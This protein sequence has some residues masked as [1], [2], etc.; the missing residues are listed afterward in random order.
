VSGGCC[1]G[2][3]LPEVNGALQRLLY[4]KAQIPEREVDV[5]FEAPTK[6]WN[7]GLTRPAVS[8]YL[9]ELQENTE[10]RRT[11]FQTSV[12]N[13]QAIRRLPPR[14]FNLNYLV[15]AATTVVDDEHR[16]LWRVL[17][18][19]MQHATL[20]A[21]L[22]PEALRRPEPPVLMRVLP[23]DEAPRLL[24]VWSALGATPR[25]AFAFSITVP[26]DVELVI[27]APLVLTRTARVSQVQANGAS[28]TKVDIGGVIRDRSGTPLEGVIVT[29]SGRGGGGSITDA[30]GRFRLFDVP[31]GELTLHAAP[32]GGAPA[33]FTVTVPSDSYDLELDASPAPEMAG[34][35]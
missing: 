21:E 33:A 34:R 2:G 5:R 14:R 29:R 23:P 32:A 20:P 17:V 18:T 19:L 13:G 11:D 25:P 24:E 31:T 26:V 16:L 10:L 6:E 30:Y 9:F 4:E 3:V 1:T 7:E 15:S 35:N 27:H 22:L 8:L 12:S 28:T